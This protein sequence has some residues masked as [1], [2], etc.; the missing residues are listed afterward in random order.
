MYTCVG[1]FISN[2]DAIIEKILQT[3]HLSHMF[4]LSSCL[5]GNLCQVNGD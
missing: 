4:P 2:V 3:S 5:I 1:K